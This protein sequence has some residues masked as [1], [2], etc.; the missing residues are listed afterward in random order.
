MSAK[1]IRDG[2]VAVILGENGRWG[3]LASS[4]GTPE[5][6]YCPEMVY[7]LL[8]GPCG[9]QKAREIAYQRFPTFDMPEQFEVRWVP[10]GAIFRV[11]Y[12]SNDEG[13]SGGYETI[14]VFDQN[15]WFVA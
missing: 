12:N 5:M 7:A 6:L 1:V 2:K 8:E 4:V 3:S 14:E 10:L 11:L 9:H 13:G 15:R